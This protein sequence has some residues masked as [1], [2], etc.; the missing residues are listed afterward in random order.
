MRRWET[1]EVR[2]FVL[3]VVLGAVAAAFAVAGYR[4]A[5]ADPPTPGR[6]VLTCGGAAGAAAARVLALSGVGTLRLWDARAVL[7]EDL[8]AGL[9][10]TGRCLGALLTE[11]P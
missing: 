3:C 2:D 4:D 5:R 6:Y 1:D 11:T 9:T 10:D 7:A 8:A